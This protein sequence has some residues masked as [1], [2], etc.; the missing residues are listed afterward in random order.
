MSERVMAYP[1]VTISRAVIERRF[2]LR[3][4]DPAL[5]SSIIGLP[6]PTRIGATEGAIAC[7]GPDEY[8]VRLPNGADLPRGAGQPISIVDVSHRAIGFVVEGEGALMIL[9]SGCPLDLARFAIGRTTRTLFETVEI[10]ITRE[11]ETSWHIDVWR[12]FAPWLW[13]AMRAAAGG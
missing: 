1:D 12:S 13:G 5:L 6:L 4:R 2:S 8:Y 11:G 9:S 10:I 7:L 3:A